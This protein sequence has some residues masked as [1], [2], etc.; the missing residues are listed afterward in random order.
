MHQRFQLGFF[1][2]LGDGNACDRGVAR[3]RDHGVAVAAEDECRNVFDADFEFIGNEGAEAGGIEHSGHADH[4]LARKSAEL[5]GGLGHGVQRIRDNDQ[6]AVGRMLNGF[7]DYGFHDVV[8]RVEK[9]VAAH[10]G[11]ARDAGSDD[12]DVGVGGVFVVVRSGDVGVA[13]LDGHGFEQIEAFALRHAFDDVDKDDVGKFFGGDP[14]SGGGAY[15]AGADDG[16]FLAH[17]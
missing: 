6:N 9:I 10:A 16:Y 3:E 7:A 15:V 12:Y 13:L 1:D 4:A 5:V 11:L 8:V 14:V 17:E 2:Q